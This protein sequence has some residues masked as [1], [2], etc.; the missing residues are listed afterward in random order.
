MVCGS[1][2]ET[3]VTGENVATNGAVVWGGGVGVLVLAALTLPQEQSS[4]VETATAT[5]TRRRERSITIPP[6]NPDLGPEGFRLSGDGTVV[7]RPR[8]SRDGVIGCWNLSNV[9]LNLDR[10]GESVTRVSVIS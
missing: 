3:I 2:E 9:I 10:N 6:L 4:D 5:K 1:G 8:V 7:T